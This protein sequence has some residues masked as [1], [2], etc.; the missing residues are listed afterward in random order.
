MPKQCDICRRWDDHG[1]GK[2]GKIKIPFPKL[3]KEL[4]RQTKFHICPNCAMQVQ[5]FIMD[6]MQ[7][8]L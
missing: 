3:F 8:E 6:N 1:I 5:K 2:L 4:K 7:A